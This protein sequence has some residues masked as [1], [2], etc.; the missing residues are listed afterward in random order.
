[1]TV[2]VHPLGEADTLGQSLAAMV[3]TLR[4]Q[5]NLVATTSTQ[6]TRR[7]ELL[8]TTGKQIGESSQQIAQA[9][10]EVARGAGEQ[11]RNSSTAMNQAELTGRTDGF[12]WSLTHKHRRA[13]VSPFPLG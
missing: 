9:I 13:V 2:Q 3:E 4:S 1:L 5:I 8:A 11:S 7:A 6:V 10:D 12:C